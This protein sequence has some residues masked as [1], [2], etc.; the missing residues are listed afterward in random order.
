MKGNPW[1]AFWPSAAAFL[2]ILAICDALTA[3]LA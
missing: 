2:S 1:C 3:I